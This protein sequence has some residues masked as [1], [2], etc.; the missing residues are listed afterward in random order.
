MSGKSRA[1]VKAGR[2]ASGGAATADAPT[3]AP[4]RK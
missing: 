3:P 1:E 4:V 2:D